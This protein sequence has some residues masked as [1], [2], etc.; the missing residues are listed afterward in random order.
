MTEIEIHQI[1]KLQL[2]PCDEIAG[3]TTYRDFIVVITQRGTVYRI[4]VVAS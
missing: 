4:N 2:D 3:I 1:A